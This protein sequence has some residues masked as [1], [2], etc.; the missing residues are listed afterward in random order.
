MLSEEEQQRAFPANFSYC[1]YV[2]DK[3]RHIPTK[4]SKANLFVVKSVLESN[5]KRFS[6]SPI[7]E[8]LQPKTWPADTKNSFQLTMQL[9]SPTQRRKNEMYPI[10]FLCLNNNST[11]SK[12][13][14]HLQK[15]RFFSSLRWSKTQLRHQ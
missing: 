12:I 1:R 13:R 3:A 10:S 8:K 14:I 11:R 4:N 7:P 5:W 6:K 9:A 2:D 15:N